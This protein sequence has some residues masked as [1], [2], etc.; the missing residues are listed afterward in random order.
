MGLEKI[1]CINSFVFVPVFY[2]TIS[3]ETP[4]IVKT[5]LRE[6]NIF[7][8]GQ[9]KITRPLVGRPCMLSKRGE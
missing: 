8:R 9:V 2:R 4:R 5:K 7:Y 6:K 3:R 1:L